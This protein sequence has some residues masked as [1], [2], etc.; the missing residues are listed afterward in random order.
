MRRWSRFSASSSREQVILELLFVRPGRAID[1]L[2]HRV[3]RIAAPVGARD[4]RQL[5]GAEL[6]GRWHVRSAAQVFPVALAVERDLLARRDG[7]DDLGLVVLADR[8]EVRDR[9]I[10]RQHA[11][12]HRLIGLHELP[13]LRLEFLEVLGREGPLE[14][15]VVVEAV[16]DDRADRDLR[17]RVDRLHRL[18]QQVRGRMADDFEAFG[19]LRGDDAEPGI[20]I[21]HV[22]RIDQPAIDIAGK[23]R[24]RQALAD[25]GSDLGHRD[26]AVEGPLAAVG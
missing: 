20:G 16:L 3:L 7:G 2:Q 24:A 6:A 12:V 5:E 18:R 21:D 23:R 13:H 10:A 1:A 17:L 19:I 8:L 15:E 9:R 4:L 14:G 26:R 25:V 22:R 11:P